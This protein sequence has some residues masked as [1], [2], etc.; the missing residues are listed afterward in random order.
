MVLVVGPR[1]DGGVAKSTEGQC[2]FCDC[3]GT[4][5]GE[6]A[7][8]APACF[9]KMTLLGPGLYW[10]FAISYL[11]S[12]TLTRANLQSTKVLLSVDG[13]Q[14][15]VA[16]AECE[17]D[18]LF[19]HVADISS[20]ER[21]LDKVGRFGSNRISSGYVI[22]HPVNSKHHFTSGLLL[23]SLRLPLLRKMAQRDADV[24]PWR[25]GLSPGLRSSQYPP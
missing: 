6:P 16:K 18:L 13:Y 7:P 19:C 2:C 4:S 22:M 17:R 11:D 12:K 3:T 23:Y 8:W 10:G 1:P 9:V 15:I 14:V 5:V 20:P 21:N 24:I 25:A